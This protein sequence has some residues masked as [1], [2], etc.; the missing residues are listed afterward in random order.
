MKHAEIL[1]HDCS[2]S[3]RSGNNSLVFANDKVIIDADES[4]GIS[5]QDAMNM[6]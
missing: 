4:A 5:E 2:E 1:C 6:H 3:I